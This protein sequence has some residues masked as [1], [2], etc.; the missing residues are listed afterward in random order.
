MD[1]GQGR[2]IE[3]ENEERLALLK[4][5]FPLHGGVFTKGE[6]VE[7]KGSR[8]RIKTISPKEL[9]LKLLPKE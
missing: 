7:L 9:R 5:D 8:F 4:E 2:F 3:A 1:S 6:I